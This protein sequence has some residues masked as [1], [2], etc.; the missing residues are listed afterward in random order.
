M[1]TELV[2][3]AI[4]SFAVIVLSAAVGLQINTIFDHDLDSID[5]RKKGL[6]QAMDLLGRNQLKLL[7][8]IEFLFC[9]TFVFLLLL[10]QGKPALLFMWIAG[11]F[12]GYAYSAPPLRLKS[13]CWL[14]L[15]TLL[16][17]LCI[18]PALFVFHTF[19][20]VLGPLFLLFLAG[21]VLS[22]YGLILPTEIRDYFED[23]A[24]GIETMTVRLGLVKASFFSII[25]LS[26]GGILTGT[27]LFLRLAYGLKPVL[28]VF[29]PTIAVADCI[30]LRKLKRLHS[31]SR[32]YTFSKNQS[33]RA[34]DI[35]K[36]AADSPRLVIL[37]SQS[38]VFM[39]LILLLGKLLP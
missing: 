26:A 27:A 19:T 14:S 17:V 29:L 2:V 15:G 33:S 34:Q 1:F 39:S 11:I 5:N 3:P 38:A 4:L 22:V 31:L 18:L 35:R 28:N 7:V 36:L 12:L 16:F 9:F 32:E 13:R 6:A 21:Q 37:A 8:A 20:S 24:M 10:N 23:R 30:V 25:F